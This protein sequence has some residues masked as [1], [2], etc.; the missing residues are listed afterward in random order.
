MKIR[1]QLLIATWSILSVILITGAFNI[2][3]LQNLYKSSREVV[4]Q[5]MPLQNAVTEIKLNTTTAHLWFEEIINGNEKKSMI[6]IVWQLL[7]T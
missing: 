2:I 6:K 4:L 1:T 5:K 3:Q 7:Q